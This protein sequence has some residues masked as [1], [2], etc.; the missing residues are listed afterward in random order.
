MPPSSP[1]IAIVDA[2]AILRGEAT[3]IRLEPGDIVYLPG[4]KVISA[5]QI[6]R[7]AV[8][9]FVQVVAAN[10]GA[11]AGVGADN[12]SRV[13]VTVPLGVQ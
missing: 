2:A 12:A 4:E 6:G 1:R 7:N 10:E 3:N 13:G 9:T 8:D 5:D 11:N